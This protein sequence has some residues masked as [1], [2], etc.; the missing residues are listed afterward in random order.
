MAERL[1]KLQVT[2]LNN[3]IQDKITTRL[4]EWGDE[5]D[6]PQEN[7]E[8]LFEQLECEP[9]IENVIAVL[10]QKN[11][12]GMI[13][14]IKI[15]RKDYEPVGVQISILTRKSNALQCWKEKQ[16]AFGNEL[17]K[18]GEKITDKA[19]FIGAEDAL[20]MLEKF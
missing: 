13:F 20:A 19:V 11:T 2:H 15:D 5:N 16:T 18:E 3:K 10:K 7:N 1:T 6:R 4:K 9:T 12:Q 14:K 17:T 8:I